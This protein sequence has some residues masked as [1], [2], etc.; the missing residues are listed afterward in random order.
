MAVNV[1]SINSASSS[2]RHRTVWQVDIQKPGRVRSG[3]T[4]LQEFRNPR[5]GAIAVNVISTNSASSSEQH[6]TVW[7]VD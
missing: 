6:G 1:I 3:A 5:H 2:E 4:V 7:Q